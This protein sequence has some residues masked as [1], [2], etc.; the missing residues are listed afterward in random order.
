MREI[1]SN[2]KKEAPENR[3]ESSLYPRTGLGQGDKYR[4]RGLIKI[5][6]KKGLSYEGVISGEVYLLFKSWE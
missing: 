4:S 3:R 2:E 1:H 6:Q 5:L